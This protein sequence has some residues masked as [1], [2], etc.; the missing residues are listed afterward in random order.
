MKVYLCKISH[1]DV[2]CFLLCADDRSYYTSYEISKQL[3]LNVNLYNK[4]LVEQVIKHK[5]YS[6]NEEAQLVS[7]MHDLS[8][9]L[10]K[11]KPEVYI[12]RF[13][14]VFAKELTLLSLGGE[15]FGNKNF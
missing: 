13:K 7:L 1:L 11:V 5:I 2:V 14:D 6:K 8:F 12:E 9:S 4:I 15:W 3:G 10:N